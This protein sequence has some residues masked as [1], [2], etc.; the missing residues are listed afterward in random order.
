MCFHPYVLERI[1]AGR[2]GEMHAEAARRRAVRSLGGSRPGAQAALKAAWLR[3]RRV[4][5]LRATVR[6]RHA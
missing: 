5:G 1:T 4:L 3:V 2:L 6:H